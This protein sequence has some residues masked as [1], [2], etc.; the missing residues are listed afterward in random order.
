M[1]LLLY[2]LIYSVAN[3]HPY[4]PAFLHT[5]AA[6]FWWVGGGEGK[7]W[8]KAEMLTVFIS[9]IHQKCSFPSLTRLVWLIFSRSGSNMV[10]LLR[11]AATYLLHQNQ[12]CA[13][14]VHCT[15]Y[16]QHTVCQDQLVQA[17]TTPT[18]TTPSPTATHHL[19]SPKEAFACATRVVFA[20]V[21]CS[22]LR[23]CFCIST[24]AL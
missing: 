11:A 19:R 6:S 2:N 8:K 3:C 10:C 20:F 17:S 15:V 5:T 4:T 23:Y 7:I 24:R 14:N 12:A 18:S 16:V 21:Q 22:N 9:N 13:V 1:A